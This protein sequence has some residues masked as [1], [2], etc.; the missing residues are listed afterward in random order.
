MTHGYEWFDDYF[1]IDMD[2][3][4]FDFDYDDDFDFEPYE[5]DMGDDFDDY[6]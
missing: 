6:I 1:F 3:Y 5:L 2:D 4:D